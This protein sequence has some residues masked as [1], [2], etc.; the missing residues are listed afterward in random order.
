MEANLNAGTAALGNPVADVDAAV[1]NQAAN[2]AAAAGRPPTIGQRRVAATEDYINSYQGT[3][4][5]FDAGLREHLYNADLMT[6]AQKQRYMTDIFRPA[7]APMAPPEPPPYVPSAIEQAN[8]RAA[9]QPYMS[10]SVFDIPFASQ[11]EYTPPTFSTSDAEFAASNDAKRLA[12]EAEMNRMNAPKPMA[13]KMPTLAERRLEALQSM[14]YSGP[15][16]GLAD[17]IQADRAELGL[18]TPAEQEKATIAEMSAG[19]EGDP[20]KPFWKNG[21]FGF[22]AGFG[23]MATIS[24]ETRAF[25]PMLSGESYLP[26][27]QAE[28]AITGLG[29][30]IGTLAGGAL[31]GKFGPA[32]VAGGAF[33]GQSVGSGIE[34]AIDTYAS[35]HT[36]AQERAGNSLGAGRG[37]VD[38]INE[39]TEALKNAATPAAKELAEF[40][41]KVGQTGAVSA[42]AAAGFGQFQIGLG[43]AFGEKS[44][45]LLGYLDSTP[46]LAA[47][48]VRFGTDPTSLSS[49]DYRSIGTLAAVSG[50]YAGMDAA[51]SYAA[52]ASTLEAQNP[53]YTKDKSLVTSVDSVPWWQ[54]A[55]GMGGSFDPEA[56]N[57]ARARLGTEAQWTNG[58]PADLNAAIRGEYQQA[59]ANAATSETA[60]YEMAGMSEVLQRTAITGGSSAI[61]SAAIGFGRQLDID[62]GAISSTEDILRQGLL[63]KPGDPAL[64]S[65]LSSFEAQYEADNTREFQI[66]RLAATTY[67]GEQEATAGLGLSQTRGNLQGY[68]LRGGSYQGGA[69]Q[70]QDI[71]N[72]RLGF[73]SERDREATNP[74][75][76]PQERA[77]LSTQ[78]QDLRNQAAMDQYS[79]R[80]SDYQQRIGETETGIGQAALGVSRSQTYGDPSSYAGAFAGL[81][82]AY[83]AKMK[84]LSDELARGGLTLDD[85]IKKTQE[86]TSVR[87]SL[88]Q[89]P[90]EEAKAFY[91]TSSSIDASYTAVGTSSSSIA[92]MTGGSGAA[93]AGLNAA[94]DANSN[95]FS[96]YSAAANDPRLSPADRAN[97]LAETGRLTQQAMGLQIEKTQFSFAPLTQARQIDIEGQLDRAGK[98][99]LEQGNLNQLRGE[100]FS[101]ANQAV[102]DFDKQIAGIKKDFGGTI[103]DFLQPYISQTRNQL[104]G[105]RAEIGYEMDKSFFDNL[106]SIAIG[107]GSF[108]ER[109]LPSR[110]QSAMQTEKDGYGSVAARNF[111]YFRNSSG[112]TAIMEEGQ[113][114]TAGKSMGDI[115]PGNQSIQ[116]LLHGFADALQKALGGVTL[117]IKVDTGSG[118]PQRQTGHIQTTAARTQ[119][120]AGVLPGAGG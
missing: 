8:A 22:A 58:A 42:G 32:G 57:Q 50:D 30:I 9:S 103:P 33:I 26:S 96:L 78:A 21:A 116:A 83:T 102:S 67:A 38:A 112:H 28:Q 81:S 12:W 47:Q 94:F 11:N 82:D 52:N 66:N 48:R 85:T 119:G 18:L 111:G 65:K 95:K 19:L 88:N 44:D 113:L 16:S 39:F 1:A 115:L 69:S 5:D 74:L 80:A 17:A 72:N 15:R 45:A 90:N 109:L 14:E 70:E 100:G 110:A 99:F 92:R 27:Q 41:T 13:V 36:F 31:G 59:R 4:E 6:N 37:G 62:R 7:A 114:A 34:D 60:G 104:L 2:E 77:T 68:I 23:S 56:V 73:A 105:K 53:Q 35:G 101:L 71:I 86:L 49:G 20:S 46:Q 51:L 61:S 10:T 25:R 76:S 117:S 118:N 29:P 43:T 120:L 98:S 55:I 63:R 84:E 54:R 75:F 87:A 106:P 93:I 108:S 3:R 40:L 97:A 64:L 89:L 79:Y 24:A 91:S 107:G